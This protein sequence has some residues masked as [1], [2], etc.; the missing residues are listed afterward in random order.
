MEIECRLQH[1]DNHCL[2]S[3]L[4]VIVLKA[5]PIPIPAKIGY[6]FL[7]GRGVSLDCMW[8]VQ[9]HNGPQP[10]FHPVPLEPG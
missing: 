3:T 10:V 5:R 7:R 8:G 9:T 1:G 6:P 4:L 2:W